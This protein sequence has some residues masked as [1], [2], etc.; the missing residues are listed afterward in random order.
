MTRRILITGANG[1]IGSALLEVLAAEYE[2]WAVSRNAMGAA[3]HGCHQ[4]QVDLSCPEATGTLREKLPAEPFDAVLHLAALT[5]RSGVREM[6]RLFAVNTFGTRYLLDGLA[7][8][9]SRCACFSTVDVY[10]R[11]GAD[12]I[13]CEDYPVAPSNHYALSKYA[14]ERVACGWERESGC[15]VDIFRLGQVYGPGDP[16]GKVIPAFCTAA[17]AGNPPVIV[18]PGDDLRQPIHVRDVVAAVRSWLDKDPPAVGRTFLL[19]GLE[20]IS[21]RDLAYLVM[22][23]SGMEGEPLIT[24]QVQ[25]GRPFH[26]RC[27]IHRTEVELGWVPSVPLHSGISEILRR[28]RSEKGRN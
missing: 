16:T 10:G 22:A 27:D 5:P 2:I 9:P 26:I 6:E 18:G 1:F 19:A 15:P 7:V 14:G 28:M 25:S 3:P 17:I 4:I 23:E 21:V 12:D 8:A 13:F 24:P 20:R 11:Q